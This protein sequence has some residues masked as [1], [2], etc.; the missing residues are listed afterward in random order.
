MRQTVSREFRSD[1]MTYARLALLGQGPFSRVWK[2]KDDEGRQ[3]ALKELTLGSD[4]PTSRLDRFR[5][6]IAIVSSLRHANIVRL[7]DHR[8]GAGTSADP[9]F[10][11]MPLYESSL[12]SLIGAPRHPDLALVLFQQLL[13]G[14]EV[15]H[16]AGVVHRDLKPE[17]ILVRSTESGIA[18]AIADF[19]IAS[20]AQPDAARIT[21]TGERLANAVYAAP[22]Q[23]RAETHHIDHRVDFFA[24]GLMLAELVLGKPPLGSAPQLIGG[25]YPDAAYV[26][27]VVAQLTRD[28]P[29]AR[30]ASVSSIRE[31]LRTSRLRASR[32]RHRDEV[33]ERMCAA[34]EIE[35]QPDSLDLQSRLRMALD[36]HRGPS[37]E[38]EIPLPAVFRS[39]IGRDA[40]LRFRMLRLA[41]DCGADPKAFEV[42]WPHDPDAD[43]SFY[44]L[45]TER[46]PAKH[47]QY[48]PL[49]EKYLD[50]MA[51]GTLDTE[52]SYGQ[53]LAIEGII[54]SILGRPPA[55]LRFGGRDVDPRELRSP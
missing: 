13:D 18:I 1:S 23:R 54:E 53:V 5:R 42:T 46:W 26:D 3:V 20:L 35:G 27:D 40:D 6:E 30:P 39:E 12:R 22:E 28:E 31:L 19:G 50:C 14:V 36:L 15:A 45:V 24:L 25:L 34:L 44:Q 10:F 33:V 8:A 29:A 21:R 52:M 7:L 51:A 49:L 55:D 48:R 11:V 37:D 32:R 41:M 38:G 4:T 47:A 16:G 43:K 9:C 2:V 17:N